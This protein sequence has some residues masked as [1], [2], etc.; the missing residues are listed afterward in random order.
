MTSR[1]EH[2]ITKTYLDYLDRHILD[3]VSGKVDEF[4]EINQIAEDLAISHQYLSEIIQKDLGHHPCHFY[5]HKIIEMAKK[6]LT[7]TQHSVAEVA[8]MLTY[9]PSNFSK[10]FKRF[11]GTTPNTY[12]KENT[13]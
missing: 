4:K 6:L 12:R 5:D 3:V 9:D 11:T 1:K 10:F 7:E 2:P 8:R 13:K